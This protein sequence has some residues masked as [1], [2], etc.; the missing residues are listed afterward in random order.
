MTEGLLEDIGALGHPVEGEREEGGSMKAAAGPRAKEELRDRGGRGL[1]PACTLLPAPKHQ[2]M[3]ARDVW[4]SAA[5]LPGA[6]HLGMWP[7]SA[8]GSGGE[9]GASAFPTPS[10]LNPE[11][12]PGSTTSL[13][14]MATGRD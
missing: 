11:P 5:P 7:D 1:L 2:E 4:G 10:V 8:R 12:Y 9:Q 14:A 6:P 3:G 13:L